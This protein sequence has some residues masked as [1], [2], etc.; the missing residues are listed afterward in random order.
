MSDEIYCD[1]R[2]D[3]MGCRGHDIEEFRTNPDRVDDPVGL[4]VALFDLLDAERDAR[5]TIAAELA[6]LHEASE[7]LAIVVRERIYPSYNEGAPLEQCLYPEWNSPNRCR[8][9]KTTDYHCDE[10]RRSDD[11]EERQDAPLIRALAHYTHD[12]EQLASK[13][14]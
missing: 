5:A 6:A 12:L 8:N 3:P 10:H 1:G 13:R 2:C 9:P 4:A 7:K 14:R 11:A